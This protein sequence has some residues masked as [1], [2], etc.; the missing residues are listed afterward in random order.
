MGLVSAAQFLLVCL[1]CMSTVGWVSQLSLF[2]VGELRV[3]IC[4]CW[5]FD[6]KDMYDN[7]FSHCVVNNL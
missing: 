1:H 3:S 7:S 2:C 6:T 5:H 4:S